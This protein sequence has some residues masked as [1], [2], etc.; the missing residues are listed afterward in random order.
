MVP[1]HVGEGR[2]G[3]GDGVG[4]GYVWEGRAAREIADGRLIRC[5]NDWCQPEDWLYLYY[6]TRKYISAGL[7]A[8]IEAMRA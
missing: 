2:G 4:L 1:A 6:P 5:L 8:V 7:R 3:V